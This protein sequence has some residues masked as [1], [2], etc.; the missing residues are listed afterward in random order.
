MRLRNEVRVWVAVLVLCRG[1]HGFADRVSAED[2]RFREPV[3]EA[4]SRGLAYLAR[5]QLPDGSFPGIAKNNAVASLCVMAFL[6]QGN[7]PGLGAYGDHI[8]RGI[9]L[10]LSNAETNGRLIGAGGGQMYSHNIATLMLS[11]VSGMA[12]PERRRRIDTVLPRAIQIILAAQKVA[13]EAKFQ[14]GWRYEPNSADSDISHSGWAMMALRSA[15]NS[16]APIP[17]EAMD[18]GVAFIRRCAGPDG[19]FGYQPGSKYGLARTG[20]ALLCLELSGCHRDETTLKAGQYILN[21]FRT[22]PTEGN[23]F[24]ATYHCSQG[25]FQLGGEEWEAFA[26]L[27][28]ERLLKLQG[29]EGDWVAPP[30]AANERAGPCYQTAMAIL[31][32]SVSHRQLPSYQR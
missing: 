2:E 15:R 32:L 30:G 19:V 5:S 4:V 6:S 22:N 14:G 31:A 17:R 27:F 8:N 29:P 12:D 25:M 21:A 16:G 11:E 7:A 13:K 18:D 28:Y 23:F 24:Y 20:V 9:D 3:D 26:P 1:L 10:V